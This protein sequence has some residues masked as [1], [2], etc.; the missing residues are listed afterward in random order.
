MLRLLSYLAPSIRAEFFALAAAVI[1]EEAGVEVDLRFEQRISGPLPGDENP[2]VAGNVDIGFVCAPSYRWLHTELEVLPVPV[3]TDTRANGAPV[4]FADVVVHRDAP[5]A[6]FDD[7]RGHAWAD[8]DR[9]SRSGWFS[10][11]ERIGPVPAGAYFSTLLHAG[12][13]V[14]SLRLVGSRAVAAAAIDS[15][16]LR[17]QAQRPDAPAA[18]TR[19]LESWGPFP[20]R[21]AVI[22]SGV[23]PALRTAVRDALLCVHEVVGARLRSFGFARFVESAPGAYAA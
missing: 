5:F 22:R 17:H 4:Y 18:H 3:P 14:E 8:N 19:I 23:P 6:T 2:F 16:V 1:A 9:N 15:N 10:M 11:L 13:H 21:P 20:I 12:S 7:L